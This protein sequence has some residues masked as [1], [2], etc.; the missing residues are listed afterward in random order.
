[1]V[2]VK[3][4]SP[5]PLTTPARVRALSRWIVER[6]LTAILALIALAPPEPCWKRPPAKTMPRL[7]FVA[8]PLTHRAK[9][10]S[11]LTVMVPAPCNVAPWKPNKPC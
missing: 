5:E 3:T 9:V 6:A 7:R 2:P 4:R 10:P 8:A 1:M 11:G